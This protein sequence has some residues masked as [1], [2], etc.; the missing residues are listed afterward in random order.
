MVAVL[1][2]CMGNIC[3]SPLAEGA[4]RKA[5]DQCGL[6]AH[7]HADSAGTLKYHVGSAPDLRAQAVA[8]DVGIDISSQRARHIVREDFDNFD[9]MLAMDRDN[10][11][12]LQRVKPGISPVRIQL[13]L[14]YAP[15]FQLDEMPD[16]YYGT[17]DDFMLVRD[18][19]IEGANGLVRTLFA[20]TLQRARGTAEE[21]C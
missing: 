2:V 9:L 12:D 17:T 7:C 10:M 6:S 1:F 16:P 3:R 8:R 18:A 13:F 14:D 15:D 19:A 4:Y 21:P 11:R 20:D 5:M